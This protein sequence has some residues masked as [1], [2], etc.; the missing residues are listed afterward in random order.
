MKRK[1]LEDLGLQKEA[2]DSIMAENGKDL[3]AVKAEK[4]TYKTRLDE[5]TETLKS[6]EGVD[7]KELQGKITKL[8]GDLAAKDV[9]TQNLI[10][11]MKFDAALKDALRA[12]GARNEKAVMAI[13]DV[14]TLKKSR[15]Q[16]K[17]ISAAIAAAKKDNDYLFQAEKPAPRVVST[18]SGMNPDADSKRS[19][20][21]EALRS[22]FGKE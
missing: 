1:F 6:F 15:N 3:E 16:E 12:A 11:G 9:E 7:V 20:A 19:Q 18:T 8:T 2:I 21:N 17:D 22:L 13:L 5:A 10:E 4:D 14:D